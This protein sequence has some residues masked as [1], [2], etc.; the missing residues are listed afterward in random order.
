MSNDYRETG[1][2]IAVIDM[3]GRFPGALGNRTIAADPRPPENKDII[4]E[5]VK[6]REA[7]RPFAPS[8][9]EEYVDEYFDLPGKTRQFPYMI[10]VVKVKPDK[11]PM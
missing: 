8:V 9:L 5:M 4:N 7:Y 3:A 2:E 10:F 1:L 6:K 11:L